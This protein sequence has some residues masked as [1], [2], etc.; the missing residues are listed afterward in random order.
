MKRIY[1][2]LSLVLGIIG[3]L[4]CSNVCR[5]D[6]FIIIHNPPPTVVP[7]HFAFAPLEVVYHHVN[8][9]INDQVATTSVDQEFFNPNSR[10]LEGTYIFPLP[11]GAHIDKFSMDINGTMMDAE[12]LPADKA[13][14]LY[15]EIVRKYRD[16]AL[17]E[18][19]GRD[20][21]KVR[22]FPIQANSRKKVKLQY[23]QLLT[24]DTG[25]VEYAYPMNT[26]KFSA[27]PLAEVSMKIT[28][29]SKDPL[30]TIYSPTNSVE[31]KREGDRRAVVGWEQKNVRPDQDFKLIFSRSKQ[32]VG[33]DLLTYRASGDDGY[34]LLLAS[35]GLQAPK[36]AIQKKDVCFILDTSGSMAGAKM[37][38]AK[39]ALSFCVNNLNEGDRF[40]VI[41]FSTE[42]E[43]LFGELK[44]AEKPNV[45]KALSFV[46]D[47]KAIGGTAISDAL[48]QALVMKRDASRPY[49]V[50]FLTDGQPTIGETS[51]DAIVAQADKESRGDTRVFCFG[52]GTDVNT[53]LLD[54]IAA[55]TRAFSQYVLPEEDIEVKV[56]NFYTKIKEP[57][58]SDVKLAFTG[59][60][61]HVSQLYPGQMPDLFK[62]EVLVAFGRY[63]G[64]GPAAVKVTGTINGESQT[65][66]TDVNFAEQD[67]ASSFIPRLWAT[68]RV[69]YLLDQIRLHGESKELKDEVT[70]LAREHGIV[71]PYTA[72]LILEDEQRR[73]VPV[74]LQ[75]F[76]EL[77]DDTAVRRGAEDRLRQYYAEA[78]N[79]GARTGK[80]ALD[81]SK[82][83]SDLKN[84]QNLDELAA[85]G[86]NA[87]LAK[88]APG[89]APA[90][91][92]FG[93]GGAAA[94]APIGALGKNNYGYHQAQN[95]TQQS[96]VLRGRAFYQN[97]NTW[98]DSTAQSRKDLKQKQIQFN[99]DDYF[100]LLKQHPEAAEWLALGNEV[101]VVIGDTLYQVR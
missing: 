76:R 84:G 19:M 95:Y 38:Q 58:L 98:T 5:A 96:R 27:R 11:A 7:G 46:K 66:A 24:A 88:R 60:D 8:V 89:A 1:H 29:N 78:Q 16:P 18:Y 72:Y 21:F 48:H 91:E 62:G 42:C 14:A 26:E 9:E 35:P 101:D 81:A 10:D 44:N 71:T 53:H 36:G 99:S 39:K 64:K 57:V 92:P 73:N 90:S 37:E 25:L 86:Q 97:G 34:F 33:V 61:I 31:I 70:R 51:E 82:D 12:L 28:L 47:L 83:A 63:S 69:G 55:D 93:A 80:Q 75:S 2:A 59:N 41:R 67:T 50:V 77:G 17:L 15:E 94:G 65:F 3:L 4:V 87:T 52:I 68:R 79:E 85:A 20:A 32:A 45:D 40:E 100:A 6:G 54:R 23:T 56:S 49:V 22:I 43:P 74:S 30:K 13:R